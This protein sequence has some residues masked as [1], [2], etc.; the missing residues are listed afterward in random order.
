MV[1]WKLEV[2]NPINPKEILTTFEGKSMAD[3]ERQWMEKSGNKYL[4]VKK[5]YT[6]WRR[7]SSYFFRLS[8]EE[9]ELNIEE[10]WRIPFQE[11]NGCQQLADGHA[12]DVRRQSLICETSSSNHPTAVP[13]SE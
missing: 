13:V 1:V 12:T 3:I 2:I 5:L 4:T 6:M 7:K 10:K 9:K 11:T 8:K